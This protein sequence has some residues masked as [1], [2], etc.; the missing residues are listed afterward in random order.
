G[1]LQFN[2]IAAAILRKNIGN[3]LQADASYK[4]GS[5]H[6]WRAG[7]YFSGE[8][9]SSANDAQVFPADAE[10]N[11]TAFT[12][13]AIADAT[14]LEGHLWGIYLQD[15]WQP[16]SQLTVNYGARFDKTTTVVNEQQFSPRLGAVYDLSEKTRVH[17]GYARYFTPPPT[18]TIDTTSIQ[19]FLNT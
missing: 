17:A 12:P 10:G 4:I 1:D 19:K 6:T 13:L 16:T 15:E 8:H 5:D 3:G 2:G 18:E 9:F 7:I 11:Q 14:H